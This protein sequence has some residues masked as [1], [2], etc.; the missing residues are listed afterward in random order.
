MAIELEFLRDMTIALAMTV[1][2]GFAASALRLS[3]IVGYLAA[4]IIVSPATPGIVVRADL[5]E[6][7][8]QL[9][10]IFLL[11]SLG[12]GFSL[13]ELRAVGK[14]GYVEIGL[15]VVLGAGMY[16]ACSLARYPHPLTM[17]ITMI[18]SSTAIGVALLRQ[19]N[20]EHHRV[21]V[22]V[23]SIAVI[24]DLIAVALVVF[25]STP[26]HDANVATVGIE[27]AKAIGFVILAILFGR[28][29]LQ[30]LTLRL[31]QNA[32]ANA[33]FG[34]FTAIALICA[35][36]GH[37][38]GLSFEFGAFIAG[39][40]VSEAAGSR[41]VQ[42]IIAPFRELFVSLFFVSVGMLF[43]PALVFPQWISVVAIGLFFVT[44]RWGGFTLLGLIGGLPR[45]LALLFGMALVP[46]GEFNIVLINESFS[47]G[48]VSK[49]EQAAVLGITFFTIAFAML[50]GPILKGL[51]AQASFLTGRGGA[52][53]T[54]PSEVPEVDAVVIGY[55]R[56]GKTVCGV[57]HRAHIRFAVMEHQRPLVAAA[58]GAG[59]LVVE[60][61]GTDPTVIE[62]VVGEGVRVVI[63]TVRDP[64]SN[65][66]MA[67]RLSGMSKAVLIT[68]AQTTAEV[69]ELIE[70]GANEAVVP[71]VE[72]AFAVGEAALRGL[73]FN[74]ED[75]VEVIGTER[76]SLIAQS[77]HHGSVALKG[78]TA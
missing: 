12:L 68:R 52:D 9:G 28:F 64:S 50:S 38:A 72:G 78:R 10:L 27:V 19:W 54:E 67:R 32:P 48:R 1:V 18:V 39:A 59:Y 34:T 61:D 36:A 71:E 69:S 55:G 14:L 22:L 66:S 56:V 40:V 33:L 49:S 7:L 25:A 29:V 63:S 3:P 44:L 74:D 2:G 17:G 65:V 4:G 35:W 43:D 21:G 6:G 60:G 15:L 62:R 46:L 51:A 26:A 75:I 37:A 8:A 24:E 20:L 76:A 58:R 70:F 57:L 16:L 31:I 47:N 77:H 30:P 5:I 42:S 23:I 41:M 11:F 53:L 45:K 73:G 13:S